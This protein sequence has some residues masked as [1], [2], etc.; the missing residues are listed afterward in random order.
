M[1]VFTTV[2]KCQRSKEKSLFEGIGGR[3]GGGGGGEWGRTP[4]SGSGFRSYCRF[5]HG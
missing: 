4:M 5:R 2:K 3:W 1:R